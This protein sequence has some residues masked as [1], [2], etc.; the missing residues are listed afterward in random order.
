MTIGTHIHWWLI[1]IPF[2]LSCYLFGENFE[3]VNTDT[4]KRTKKSRFIRN[5]INEQALLMFSIENKNA[6]QFWKRSKLYYT[7]GTIVVFFTNNE[8]YD[9]AN[10]SS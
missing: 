9:G 8:D 10:G 1:S 5:W 3:K 7:F 4:V 6:V 2:L